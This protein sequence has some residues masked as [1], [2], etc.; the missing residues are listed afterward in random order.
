MSYYLA[1]SLVQLRDELNGRW[2]GRDKSSDGWIGDAA[3]SARKSDHNPDYDDNGVVRAIDIDEDGI[4]TAAVLAQMLHD[5]RVSY[6]IYEKRIWGGTRWRPYTGANG[7]TKHIHVSIKHTAAAENGT[8]WG[9]ATASSKPKP[10]ASKPSGKGW[11][12]V[13]LEVAG[14][15]TDASHDAWVKLLAAIDYKDKSLTTSMQRWLSKLKDP[16]TGKGYYTGLIE[17]DHG[18]KTVF[19]PMLVKALQRKLYDTKGDGGKPAHLYNGKAD[20]KRE[21]LTIKAEFAYLNLKANRGVK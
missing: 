5:P 10:P 12:A 9:I 15:H 4:D 17:A 20:G 3:H 18:R 21:G 7:H 16:R 13:P 1:P 19:G 14:A 11:P 8:S 2:P 6:V